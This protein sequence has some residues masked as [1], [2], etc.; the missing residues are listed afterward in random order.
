[1]EVGAWLAA[2][3]LL[4]ILGTAA[5]QNACSTQKGQDGYAGVPG[6]D[7]RP[8]QKGDRGDTGLPGR[9]TGVQGTKG[10]P[11]D[12]GPLGEPG[13]LGYKGPVGPLGPPG[14]PGQKGQKGTVADISNQNR[15][16]FSAMIDPA[17]IVK[18]DNNVLLFSKIITNEESSYYPNSGKF[19]CRVPGYYYFTF[20]VISNG[21]LCLYIVKEHKGNAEKLVAFC[22]FNMQSHPQVNSGGTVLKLE[23]S[24]MVWIETNAN[25]NLYDRSDANSV[26]SGFLLFPEKAYISEYVRP[27]CCSM[28]AQLAV[29]SWVPSVVTHCTMCHCGAAHRLP[30]HKLPLSKE[31]RTSAAGLRIKMGRSLTMFLGLVLLLLNLVTW[32]RSDTFGI[33]GLPGVPGMPG[34]DGRDGLKGPKGERGA[35]ATPG[36]SGAKGEKGERGV[37]GPRGKNGPMGPPGLAGQKGTPGPKGEPGEPGSHKH[38]YQSA[39]TVTRLTAEYPAKNSPVIFTREISNI[40]NHYDKTTGKFTCHISGLYY[41]VYHTSLTYNL[42]VIL[43]VDGEKKATFCDH[44]S[45]EQQ[46]SSGGVLLRL[47]EGQQVWLAVNEFNG[48][49]GKENADSVFSG[50]LLFPD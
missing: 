13:M 18:I 45:N 41:F 49:V 5:P 38:R 29:S 32:V 50:F 17:A 42:C 15:P 20:H 39:F 47:V 40:N 43:Y 33:P 12:P 44:R 16:A 24:N 4:V 34:R 21:N 10:D 7:G 36:T 27:Y 26:F 14:E 19:R 22:D 9:R 6:R 25:N 11:G 28:L 30:C 35:P 46:V 1:M 3:A 2:V 8:G 37:P 31:P 23:A 48:M